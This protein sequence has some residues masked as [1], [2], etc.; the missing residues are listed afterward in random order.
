MSKEKIRTLLPYAFSIAVG[1]V[2]LVPII[3][4]KPEWDVFMHPWRPETA[5]SLLLLVFLGYGWLTG[6]LG[7]TVSS[8]SRSEKFLLSH[9]SL[10][11]PF[12]AECRPYGQIPFHR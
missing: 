5:A 9:R 1:I 8:F 11:L 7:K 10:F 3:N 4:I 12:G 6:E 2:F